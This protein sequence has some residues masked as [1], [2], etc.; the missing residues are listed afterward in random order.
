MHSRLTSFCALLLS[1]LLIPP[2]IAFDTPLS[3]EAVRDAY[4]LGQRRGQDFAELLAKYTTSLPAPETGPDISSITLLTPF[5]L[6]AQLSSRRTMNYSAQ[7]A[8]QDHRKQPE[9]VRIIIQIQLTPTYGALIPQALDPHKGAPV[10][11][12]QRPYDFWKDFQVTFLVK[13]KSIAP[14]DA[15]GDPI[16]S[17]DSYG[18]CTLSGATL[19]F[20][21]PARAFVSDTTTIQV[22]PPE[23]DPVSLDIDL[24]RLR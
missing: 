4:F 15:S 6:V 16:Y 24:S 7:Q 13:D 18:G 3:P 17:C 23:G 2:A 9:L 19:Q 8:E 21:Y 11:Y 5:A 1:F 20:D 12:V 22:F 14:L 10:G